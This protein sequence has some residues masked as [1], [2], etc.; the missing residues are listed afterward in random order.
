MAKKV[1]GM[2][3]LQLP[4]GKATPAPPVGPALGQHGVN[5]MGFCKE[6]NA[7][8]ADK[9]GLIIPVVITVY[10]DRSFS[11]ILKTPPAAVLIK[12]ELGL[13]SGSGVPNRT[14]VGNITKEQIRKIA[15]LKMPDLNAATIET[16]MSMIE[17]TARSMGVVVVE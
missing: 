9:A 12:K 14:K 8:T 1:T 16:A 2:I 6:F 10:Q 15:E 13:E 3:K 7:K 11:F 17:G 5:I 4:A